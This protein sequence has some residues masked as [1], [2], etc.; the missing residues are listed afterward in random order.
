LIA[1]VL[2]PILFGIVFVI[3]NTKNLIIFCRVGFTHP[4]IKNIWNKVGLAHPT[5]FF[6]NSI[7]QNLNFTEK[8]GNRSF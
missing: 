5:L 4:L 3:P 2:K 6:E 8:I 1:I 7:R